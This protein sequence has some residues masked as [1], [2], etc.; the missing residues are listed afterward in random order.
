M[1]K[2]RI[3]QTHTGY[4]GRYYRLDKLVCFIYWEAIRMFDTKEQA[5]LHIKHL[6]FQNNIPK[7]KVIEYV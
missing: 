5:H 1:K 7:D 3:V 6:E 4:G 2:Y